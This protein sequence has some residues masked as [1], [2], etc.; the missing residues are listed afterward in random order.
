MRPLK[1][2]ETESDGFVNPEYIVNIWLFG[3]DGIWSINA[4]TH[5]PCA[6]YVNIKSDFK[7]KNEA[8]DYMFKLLCDIGAT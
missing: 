7:N 3:K 4:T 1:W 6:G 2:I 5:G 8:M